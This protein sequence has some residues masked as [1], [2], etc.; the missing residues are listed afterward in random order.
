MPGP[1]R[2][3]PTNA[4][5]QRAYRQRRGVTRAQE[6]AAKGMP[7]LPAIATFPGAV[8]WQALIG[9]AECMLETAATEMQ[10]YYEDRT[11]AWQ[12]SERGTA[13]LERLEALQE[14]A[15]AVVDLQNT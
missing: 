14:A 12:E 8:R 15:S 4:A 2:D 11:E 9:N 5:R 6:Q 13:F 1:A 10:G 7:P 3:Y